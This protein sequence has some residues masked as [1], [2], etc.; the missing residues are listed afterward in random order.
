MGKQQTPQGIKEMTGTELYCQYNEG[1]DHMFSGQLVDSE[2]S[3][4]LVTE[5]MYVQKN[6]QLHANAKHDIAHAGL[7]PTSVL[8]QVYFCALML[9]Q[10]RMQK[11]WYSFCAAS[12]V[13]FLWRV[14]VSRYRLCEMDVLGI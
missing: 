12:V 2:L 9:F 3:F 10:R 13:I 4:A 11:S 7:C 6:W 1:V 5:V 8:L 14:S